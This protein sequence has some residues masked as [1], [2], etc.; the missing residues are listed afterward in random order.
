MT[1][2]SR[3]WK[4]PLVQFLVLGAVVIGIDRYAIGSAD[5]PRRIVFDDT[6]YRELVDIFNEGKGRKPT[7]EEIEELIVTWTQNEVL[8]REALAMGLDKGDDMIRNRV[9][10]KIRNILFNNVVTELPPEDQLEAWFEDNRI[11]YDRPDLY[12]FE[13]FLI[14]DADAAAAQALA[15]ELDDAPHPPDYETAF[16]RYPHRPGSNLVSVFGEDGGQRLLDAELEHWVPVQS[17]YGWHLARVT[18]HV[19][20]EPAV[21]EEVRHAVAKDWLAIHEQKDLSDALAAI[22]EDYDFRY[23][24]TQ[25][26]VAGTLRT[27]ELDDARNMA[28]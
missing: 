9:I 12:D 4:E 19:P 26:A 13:Q 7:E 22:V 1:T 3:L 10:L 28:P 15:A 18:R 8:Y 5:D 27:A 6:R 17:T 11:A 14:A 21:F 16:R 23:Q 25:E 2:I 20:G 24:V